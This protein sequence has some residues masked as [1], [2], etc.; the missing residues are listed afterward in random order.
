MSGI[1]FI[2]FINDNKLSSHMAQVSEHINS[3]NNKINSYDQMIKM[4]VYLGNKKGDNKDNYYPQ[5]YN[6][7]NS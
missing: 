1:I 5:L 3:A 7:N 2:F 6:L 4:I